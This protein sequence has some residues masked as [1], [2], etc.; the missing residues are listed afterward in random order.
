MNLEEDKYSQ[1]ALCR[2]MVE[3]ATIIE[4]FRQK[5]S[6]EFDG[7]IQHNPR[8]FLTGEGSSRIFPAK[9]MIYHVRSKGY[10]LEI[11]TEGALQALE[12]DL[13][14]YIVFGLSN[15]GKTKELV[16]LFN[17]L[18][19]THHPSFYGITAAKYSPV[20]WIP[21][22]SV[23]LTCGIEKAVPATKSVMEEALILESLLFN[24]RNSK[25]PNLKI[26]SYQILKTLAIPIDHK[27]VELFCKAPVIYFAGRNDGVAEELTL[28]TNEI[29]HKKSVFLEGT[30]ALHG[31]EEV[32][33]KNE[34]MIIIE[35][36]AQEEEKFHNVIKE[37][38]GIEIVAI[39]SRTTR[40]PTI[41]IPDAG[42]FKNYLELAA[43][44]NLLV[45]AG[46]MM[47]INIDA[48]KRARKIGNEE[49]TF[50]LKPIT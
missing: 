6:I 12:Y 31:I 18:K 22:K 20:D 36:Y 49:D 40:F 16:H 15:S 25:M 35:P 43:G 48:P 34:L 37:G 9:H 33:E 45:E 3:T 41:L 4:N 24:Y 13:A 47:G 21:E 42:E 2:E 28:K 29:T 38:A 17:R 7:I 11:I 32:M 23:I 5:V 50:N 44:W 10:P 39:S 27:I 26:L 8:V 30:Y 14:D 46:L 19:S 1:F